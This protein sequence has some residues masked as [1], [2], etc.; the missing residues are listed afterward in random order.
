MWQ[1]DGWAETRI[2]VLTPELDVCPEAEFRALAAAAISVHAARV[3]RKTYDPGEAMDRTIANERVRAFADPPL[4]DDAAESLAAAPLH[5]IA[6]CFTS[7][8]YLR[9]AADDAALKSRLEARTR[10]IPVVIT[11][12]AAIAALSAL[13]TQRLALVSPPWFSA[14]L[15]QQGAKYF[16][17]PGLR[18]GALRTGGSTAGSAGH[19]ARRAL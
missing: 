8:S 9:G 11:A 14:D 12:A 19:S 2:G 3:R 5:A 1:P 7:S 6:Y 18:G 10:G 13:G 4:A 17:E 16:E 15:D